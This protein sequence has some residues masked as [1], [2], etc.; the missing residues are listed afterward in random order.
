VIKS[1]ARGD[2]PTYRRMTARVVFMSISVF[3]LGA[4][5][6][7]PLGDRILG[8]LGK[9]AHLLPSGLLV[10]FL[11]AYLMEVHLSIHVTLYISTNHVPFVLPALLSGSSIVV[12]GYLLLPFYGLWGVILTQ[13]VVQSLCNYWY[14]VYLSLSLSRW[15]F[16]QYLRAL[17]AEGYFLCARSANLHSDE[18][19]A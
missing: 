7:L 16:R 12:V 8:C 9:H 11:F 5:L 14:P 6:L 10:L 3:F 19:L 17:V 15:G 4:V 18:R 13:I 2:L 1:L